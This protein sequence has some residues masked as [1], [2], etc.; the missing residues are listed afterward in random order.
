MACANLQGAWID[1]DMLREIRKCLDS[2]EGNLGIE[3]AG[4]DSR[5]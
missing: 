3:R 1:Q 2:A 5:N 4:R